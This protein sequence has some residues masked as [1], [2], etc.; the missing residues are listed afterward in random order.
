MRY[1]FLVCFTLPLIAAD[2]STGD[3]CGPFPARHDIVGSDTAALSWTL[4][5]LLLRSHVA[6]DKTLGEIKRWPHA[7]SVMVIATYKLNTSFESLRFEHRRFAD[8]VLVFDVLPTVM[9]Q[10]IPGASI[11]CTP[12]PDPTGETEFTVFIP[13]AMEVR[14]SYY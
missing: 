5:T 4:P 8:T 14:V 3:D 9:V 11:D 1:F 13:E 12:A 10:E 6:G 7:D 2:C